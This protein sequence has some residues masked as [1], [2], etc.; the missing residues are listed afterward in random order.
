MSDFTEILIPETMHIETEE[1]TP[2]VPENEQR[3]LSKREEQMAAIAENRRLA[4]ERE[5]AYGVVMENEA[6]A[7]GGGAPVPETPEPRAVADEPPAQHTPATVTGAES[8]QPPASGPATADIQQRRHIVNVGGQQFVVNDAELAHLA[9]LG[10]TTQIALNQQPREQLPAP[11]APE[12]RRVAPAIDPEL[13][14]NVV[15]RINYGNEEEA[16]TALTDFAGHLAQQ[17]QQQP[18]DPRQ[19][20]EQAKAEMRQ[21]TMVQNN[22]LTIGREFPEVFGPLDK[23]VTDPQEAAR[24]RRASQLAALAL[25]DIR[26]RDFMLGV[27]RS[28]LEVYREAAN[29]V[30]ATIGGARP[31]SQSGQETATPAAIQAAVP[32]AHSER[33]TR[34]RAAPSL[35]S[36]VSRVAPDGDATPRQLTKSEI[37]AWMAQKRHQQSPVRSA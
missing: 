37:V 25:D 34:K 14:R 12:P 33:L 30:R 17:F 8:P 28:D 22:L 21:E 35:P 24:Y 36:A 7:A 11:P 29:E 1:Q 23:P 32:A 16:A 9:S 6:R 15:R 19:L 5:Q 18:V 2:P 3:P 4:I 13:T 31:A 27:Q 10:A 20:V 26:R